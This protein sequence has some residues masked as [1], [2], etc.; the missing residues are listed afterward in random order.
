MPW[1][2]LSRP[3]LKDPDRPVAKKPVGQAYRN[4]PVATTPATPARTKKF[5]EIKKVCN[6][7]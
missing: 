6:F 1:M 4:R 5:G 3:S 2:P 7:A